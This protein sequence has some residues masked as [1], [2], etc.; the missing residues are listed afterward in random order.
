LTLQDFSKRADD[1]VKLR[2]RMQGDLPAPQSGS[3]GAQIKQYQTTLAQKIHDA[4][5]QARQGDFFSSPISQIFRK[6]IAA[7]LQGANGRKIRASLRHAEPVRGIKLEINRE[8]PEAAALQST[9]PTLLIDLPKLPHDL[10]YRIVGREL[11]LL[12]SSSNLVLDSL[13]DALP[14]YQDGH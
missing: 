3:S 12:D 9:P 10:E 8:Y 4:R 14:P 7:P 6:L 11:V 13:P 2:K 1:Y 5:P